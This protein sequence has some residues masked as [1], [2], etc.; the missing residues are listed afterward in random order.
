MLVT[1]SLI[2]PQALA[3]DSESLWKGV[4]AGPKAEQTAAEA[5]AQGKRG[6]APDVA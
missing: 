6:R 4:T 2:S 3:S 1:W 5:G